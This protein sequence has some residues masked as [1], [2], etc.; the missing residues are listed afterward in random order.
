MIT[1]AL[2]VV[3]AA[4]PAPDAI[5]INAPATDA[6]MLMARHAALNLF[7]APLAGKVK[8]E[9]SAS[10]KDAF[11]R[12]VLAQ[13]N[14]R[15]T[16]REDFVFIGKEPPSKNFPKPDLG[17]GPKIQFLWEKETTAGELAEILSLSLKRPVAVA[18]PY[19]RETLTVVLTTATADEALAGLAFFLGQP[20]TIG[21]DGVV[22]VGPPE[23][24]VTRDCVGFSLSEWTRVS[25]FIPGPYPSAM[26]QTGG[27]SC[28]TETGRNIR[29][30]DGELLR[31]VGPDDGAMVYRWASGPK[32]GSFVRIG[33]DDYTEIRGCPDVTRDSRLKRVNSYK[34]FALIQQGLID[35]AV[36]RNQK[37]GEFD[38]I[39]ID[40]LG[41]YV[42]NTSPG[43]K[44]P[45]VQ[46]TTG[47][48]VAA[49]A[50]V[51]TR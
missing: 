5:K 26:L 9:F 44:N 24:A 23:S 37:V 2:V 28:P 17:A 13:V 29:T 21:E 14:D 6:V 35:C 49:N 33:F 41:P 38:I 22:S 40:Q 48:I 36:S 12:D 4:A 19:D 32:E 43:A 34:S 31:S 51:Q 10:K 15:V 30:A 39:D 50:P 27:V 25:A 11:V 18:A 20:I 7:A 45:V 16:R 47:G 42:R 46:V 1:A 3:L 8:G